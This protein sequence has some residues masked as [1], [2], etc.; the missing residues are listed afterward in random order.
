MKYKMQLRE[1]LILMLSRRRK[2]LR[3]MPRLTD[4][5]LSFLL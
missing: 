5:I 2:K 3:R 1:A 4:E